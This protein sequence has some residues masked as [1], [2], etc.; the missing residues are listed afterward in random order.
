MKRLFLSVC[1]MMAVATASAQLSVSQLR[2]DHLTDP[3]GVGNPQPCLSWVVNDASRR[4]VM[5]SA[6]EVR[7]EADGRTVWK[8]GKVESAE[9]AGIAYGGEP[10]VSDTRYTWRVRV[11]DDRGKVSAW[12]RPASW[13]TGLFHKTEWQARWIEPQQSDDRAAMFRRTFRL[14]KP[15][16]AATLYIT[17]HGIYEAGINGRRVSE[18]LL[19]P[20]WTA[21]RKRLQYQAYD[22][23]PFVAKGDNAIGVTVAKGWYLSKLPWSREFNYGDEYGLLAQIVVRYKDGSREVVAT[24][25]AWRASTGAI[26]YGNLYDGET[27]DLNLRCEGWNTASFD[28]TSWTAVRTTDTPLDNLTPSVSPAVRVIETLKPVKIFTTPSGDRVIDFGQNISGRERVRLHGKRG[29]TVRIYHSE[30]LEKGEFFTRNLRKAKA[31]STYILSGEDGEWVAPHFAFY[32]FRYIKVEG[33][34]GELNP[35]DFLAEAI[36]SATPACGTFETSDSLINRLQSNIRWG[37]LGNFVDIPTDCPQRDERL[38]WTGDAQVFFRTATFNRD[39]Q[40]FFTKWMADVAA[41]QYADGAVNGVYPVTHRTRIS[42]G[43]GDAATIIPWQHYMAY[44]DLRMLERQYPSMKKWVDYIASKTENDLW[45]KGNSYGDWVFFSYSDD[46]DGRS[47][48]TIRPLIQQCFYAHSLDLVVRTARLLGAAEDVARYEALH[49]RA[50]EAFRNEYVTPNGM[51]VSDTQTAYTLAL[52]F[53]LLPEAQRAGAA[54][55]L[56]ENVNR[57][58]HITTGFLGTPYICEVLTRF[59]YADVAYKLLLNKKIPSWLYPISMGATT[60]WERW[61]SMLPNGMVNSNSMV[62]FNHYAYGAIGDWLYRWAAGLQEAAPG[63]RKIRVKPYLNGHFTS[64][65]AEQRTPYG[66]ASSAWTLDGDAVTLKVVI[67]ANTTAEVYVPSASADC[68]TESG[69]ELAA[70]DDLT[71]EGWNDGYT[72]V[73]LGSGCYEFKSLLK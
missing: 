55:R 23:T 43:W 7:V 37:M 47:A 15:V 71:P 51:L 5:Q 62:S 13:R 21:Y 20:G 69:R 28:D 49:Q 4:G 68:V 58:G 67:P 30:I 6:Y 24:D 36:S 70:C 44:G 50:V 38:G 60:I 31:V 12:S 42:A 46:L 26:S 3:L 17:A 35:D 29:D 25:D 41:E 39:V 54:K 32:G 56:V 16:A 18:D 9:S 48:V 45:N 22:V 72:L 34:D 14:S 59:G 2:C 19:T 65:K 61:N 40:T 64:M 10:L 53:D 33:I 63:F 52:M 57:Y 8:S 27:I 11:W 1:C 73:R 66:L